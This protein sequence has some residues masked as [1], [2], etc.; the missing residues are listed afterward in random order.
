MDARQVMQ[1][2]STDPL[3]VMVS[4]MLLPSS[5][6]LLEHCLVSYLELQPL[7]AQSLQVVQ[8]RNSAAL[9]NR[10]SLENLPAWFKISTVQSCSVFR[11][12]LDYVDRRLL[13]PSLK[14]D[15]VR[16]QPASSFILISTL[17][18]KKSNG[19]QLG[20]HR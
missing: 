12:I 1:R 3:N 5:G 6:L 10:N 15:P 18:S 11:P 4:N 16:M 19:P 9:T 17:Y 7:A 20:A 14:K 8:R 2:P 13:Y